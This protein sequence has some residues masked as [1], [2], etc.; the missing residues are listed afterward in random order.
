MLLWIKINIVMGMHFF[1]ALHLIHVYGVD[2]QRFEQEQPLWINKLSEHSMEFKPNKLVR[3]T[4][5]LDFA[6]NVI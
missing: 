5:H 6:T 4:F 1:N 2:V 3:N